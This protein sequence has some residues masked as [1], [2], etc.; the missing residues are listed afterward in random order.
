MIEEEPTRAATLLGASLHLFSEIGA[1]PSPDEAQVQELVEAYVLDA[2]GAE[3]VAE[4]RAAG[5]SSTLDD[6]LE[7][8]AS[9]A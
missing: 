5:A 3:Q 9:S 6:L 4:L 2:L 8:V 1:I 7:D